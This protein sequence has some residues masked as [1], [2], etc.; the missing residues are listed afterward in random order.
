VEAQKRLIGL[1]ADGFLRE[2]SAK[3]F[4]DV[5]EWQTQ[6][7][8]KP[9][10]VA[11]VQLYAGQLPPGD[12]SLTGVDMVDSVEEAVAASMKASG[13]D[14]VAVIPEGPYVVPVCREAA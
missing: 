8:V 9:M 2:I 11:R 6:M 1:G 14:Q 4:A 10:K 12:R 3:R 13:D 7:Q 5:D